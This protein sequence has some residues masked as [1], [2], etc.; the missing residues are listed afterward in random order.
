MSTVTP[1]SRG[2]PIDIAVAVTSPSGDPVDALTLE[3]YLATAKG[4][5]AI[6]SPATEMSLT[7]DETTGEYEASLTATVADALVDLGHARYF[8]AIEITGGYLAWLEIPVV[9]HRVIN[10]T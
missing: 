5:A 7:R 6:T 2:N 9:E 10:G 8:L 1:I 3:G 4:G